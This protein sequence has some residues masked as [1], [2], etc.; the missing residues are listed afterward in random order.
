MAS[1]RDRVL[2][3][4]VAIVCE[5]GERP[6]TLDAVAARAGVSKGGLLYH[7]GSKA[8]LVEGLCE[9]LSDLSAIDVE[10]MAEAEDG[11]ARYFV[12]NCLFV[13]SE[14]DL[15]LL[16]ASRLQQAGY[17][18]AGRT[19]DDTEN[20]WLATLVDALHDEP[21]AQAVK[22]LGDGLYHQASLGAASDG[23]PKRS[24]VDMEALLA[25]VDRL[26]ATKPGA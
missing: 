11:A 5:D 26:I 9:R 21:T 18:E 22:L 19:L 12:R 23:R 13:G 16:A 10:R 3:S 17:E 1:A 15:A 14:L 2:D 25:V 24:T 4:F 8:A 7:F 6:A 20:A